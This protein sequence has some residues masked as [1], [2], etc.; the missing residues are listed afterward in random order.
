[1]C[2]SFKDNSRGNT[3]VLKNFLFVPLTP[4]FARGKWASLVFNEKAKF[5]FIPSMRI[6]CAEA[7][8]LNSSLGHKEQVFSKPAQPFSSLVYQKVLEAC[9]GIAVYFILTIRLTI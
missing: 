2:L 9:S 5:E 8:L 3:R 1:M 7:P 6:T 4:N